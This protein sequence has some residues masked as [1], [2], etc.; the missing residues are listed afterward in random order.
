MASLWVRGTYT[1]GTKT[2][3]HIVRDMQ[4]RPGVM[5]CPCRTPFYYSE[6]DSLITKRPAEKSATRP[7]DGALAAC[8]RK[9]TAP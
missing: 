9:S 3:W 5:R 4:T 2:K 8:G 7:T 1:T 6:Q